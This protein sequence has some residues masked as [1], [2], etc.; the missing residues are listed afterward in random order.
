MAL[1]SESALGTLFSLSRFTGNTLRSFPDGNE[2]IAADLPLIV[3]MIA[4]T[5]RREH[6]E[7]FQEPPVWCPWAARQGDQRMD[8]CNLK[9]PRQIVESC[10]GLTMGGLRMLLFH[11]RANGLE[12]C[13]VRL[14]RKLLID[15]AAFVNWLESRRAGLS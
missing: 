12:A 14:G 7:T 5:A 6:S 10:P 9:T 13:V 2:D 15:E 3:V 1:P 4:R 8:L 11:S